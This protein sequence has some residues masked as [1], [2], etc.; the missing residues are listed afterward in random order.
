M[1]FAKS[2]S[3]RYFFTA[4]ARW[5]L[6]TSMSRSMARASFSLSR[7]SARLRPPRAVAPEAIPRSFS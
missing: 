5:F 1:A 6:Y 3:S 2:V 4:T 7:S